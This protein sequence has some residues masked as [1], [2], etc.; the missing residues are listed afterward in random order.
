LSKYL[1]ENKLKVIFYLH[2]EMRKYANLF[3]SDCSSIKIVSDDDAYDIQELLKSSAM[4]IT[5]YSSVH[6]D[7]AY[8]NKPVIY[9]QFDK[10]E[11]FDRQY[12]HSAFSAD[13]HGFGPVCYAPNDVVKNLKEIHK[14]SFKMDEL[15]YQRMRSIYQ[16]YDKNNCKRV[17]QAIEYK[18]NRSK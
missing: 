10:E 16:L 7:F 2:H 11:F 8:M 4:L 6:F 14:N 13:V 18:F 3:S 15:Y 1:L 12:K 17:A 9:Y 5:D